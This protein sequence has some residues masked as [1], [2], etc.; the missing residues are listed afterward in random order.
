MLRCINL[1]E[2]P[3]A[4]QILYHGK[5]ITSRDLDLAKYRTKVG[6]V[7]RASIFLTT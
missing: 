3:T 6:M 4:G 1:L 7:F 2:A 5:D